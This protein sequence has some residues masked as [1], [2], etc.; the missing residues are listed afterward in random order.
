MRLYDYPASGNCYKV[1][2]L[3]SLLDREYERVPIDI[4]AGDTLAP[5]FGRL[6]PARETPVLELA[7]GRVLVQSGA[8]LWYLGEGTDLMPDEAFDRGRVAQWLHFEQESIMRGIGAGRFFVLTGRSGEHVAARRE[9]AENGLD[10]LA[11]HLAE[12][13]FLLEAGPTIADIANFAYVGV[14]PDAGIDLD[15]WPAV[16]RWLERIERLPGFVDDYVPYPAN[17]RPGQGSSICDADAERLTIVT[18]AD[19]RGECVDAF[20]RYEDR[21]L[22]LLDRHGGRL[23]RRL[24]SA[25]GR[26]EVHVVSFDTRAGFDAFLADPARIAQRELLA[27]V[28]LDQRVAEVRDVRGR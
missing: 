21:V 25:E 18:W 20:Q 27:G 24:R 11:A 16:L 23:D 19:I 5:E 22:A 14:A 10:V 13:D 7:D 3:L 28:E 15:R 2:L 26:V 6:N 1:R 8:I 4:F 12:R 17:A 9:L